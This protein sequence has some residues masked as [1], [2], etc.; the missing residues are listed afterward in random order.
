MNNAVYYK[1]CE[2]KRRRS[3]LTIARDADQILCSISKFDFDGF[4]I[5]GDNLAALS[6][7]ARKIYWSTQTIIGATILDLA[8]YQMYRFHYFTMLAQFDCRLLFS[9]TDSLLYKPEVQTFMRN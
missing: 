7:R 3:Q 8:K 9:D 1:N 4:M 6:F 2:S 5:L